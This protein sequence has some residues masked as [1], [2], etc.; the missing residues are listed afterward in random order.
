VLTIDNR[1]A[2]PGEV[3]LNIGLD[4]PQNLPRVNLLSSDRSVADESGK[5]CCLLEPY[6]YRCYRVGGLDYLLKRSDR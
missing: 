1:S 6:V 4:L 2:I 3:R 5:H